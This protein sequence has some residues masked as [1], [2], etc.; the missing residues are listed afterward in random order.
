MT[1]DPAQVMGLIHER[2]TDQGSRSILLDYFFG[3]PAVWN[4]LNFS[5]LYAALPALALT[6]LL[7]ALTRLVRLI[8]NQWILPDIQIWRL[9][10]AWST[11]YALF[12]YLV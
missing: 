4:P 10:I 12:M 6:G 1:A 2:L 7:V 9:C 5:G 3:D 11:T 8:R